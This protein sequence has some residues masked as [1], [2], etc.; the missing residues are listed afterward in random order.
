MSLIF[1]RIRTLP[2]RPST[3]FTGISGKQCDV[4]EGFKKVELDL[5]NYE[6]ATKHQG[7]VVRKVDSAIRR[8]VIF[9]RAAERHKKQ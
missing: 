1:K 3:V 6:K 4:G 2:R 9:S 8:T 7:A 5:N